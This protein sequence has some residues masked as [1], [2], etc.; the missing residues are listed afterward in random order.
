M[1]FLRYTLR[2]GASVFGLS[3]LALILAPSFF[4]K[5]LGMEGSLPLVWSMVLIGVTLVALTGNMAV[6]SFTA[7][8]R[9]VQAASVV[10]MLASGGLGVTTLLIPVPLTWFSIAYALIGFGFSTVYV[11]G[12]TRASLAR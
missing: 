8:D 4:L 6:V 11:V 10:M 1:T 3:S 5:L 7:S 12:L 2:V 9:G